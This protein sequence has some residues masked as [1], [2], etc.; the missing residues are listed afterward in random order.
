[1]DSAELDAIR[2]RANANAGVLSREALVRI[3]R[4]KQRRPSY[5]VVFTCG[6]CKGVVCVDGDCDCC[7]VNKT[8]VAGTRV[9]TFSRDGAGHE[10][11]GT[12][13]EILSAAKKKRTD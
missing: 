11:L 9:S 1:M 10:R 5:A 7:R 13:E 8:T 6:R 2:A 4:E 12:V 3:W